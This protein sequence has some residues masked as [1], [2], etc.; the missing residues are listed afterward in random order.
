MRERADPAMGGK[1]VIDASVAAM[2]AVP[3]AYSDHAL[4]LVRRWAGEKVQLFTPCLML[5]EVNNAIYKRVTRKEFTMTEAKAALQVILSFPFEIKDSGRLQIRAME[6]A[7]Q[8]GRPA[9]YDCQYLALAELERCELWTG[10]RRLRNA[11]ANRL[12]WVHWVGE[13]RL[14]RDEETSA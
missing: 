3:E 9:T 4:S 5:S 10:D 13:I 1:V 2:W 12:S 11:V 6:L 7:Q 14:P 8:L